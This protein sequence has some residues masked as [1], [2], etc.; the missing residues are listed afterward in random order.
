[1]CMSG[2][3][4]GSGIRTRGFGG[5]RDGRVGINV[6]NRGWD[7]DGCWVF[8]AYGSSAAVRGSLCPVQV[9]LIYDA[10][11]LFGL[12]LEVAG[13]SKENG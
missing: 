8:W 10:I 11:L 7:E 6:V 2:A 4:D 13:S 12:D 3:T 1:M 9:R 5:R